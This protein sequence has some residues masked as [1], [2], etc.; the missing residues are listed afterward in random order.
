[1]TD[2]ASLDSDEDLTL[3]WLG[4]LPLDQHEIGAWLGYLQDSLG[5]P[6]SLHRDPYLD[7]YSHVLPQADQKAADRIA[8]LIAP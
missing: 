4:D 3:S 7:F 2:S 5:A 1:V 6:R 8:A